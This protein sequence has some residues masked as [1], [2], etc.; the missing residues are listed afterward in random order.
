MLI[1]FLLLYSLSAL[2]TVTELSDEEIRNHHMS[3]IK[4]NQVENQLLQNDVFNDCRKKN[5]FKADDT[6]DSKDLK[7]KA[8]AQCFHDNLPKD[9][10]SLKKISDTLDLQSYGLVNGKDSSSIVDY[11]T[12]KISKSLTGVDPKETDQAKQLEDLKFGKRK[13]VDQRVFLDLYTN[14]LVKSALQ[15]VSR[16]CFENLAQ[17]K[18]LKNK[19]GSSIEDYW[20]NLSQLYKTSQDKNGKTIKIADED[21]LTDIFDPK[22]SFLDT[23]KIKDL[24]D[25]KETYNAIMQGIAQQAIKPAF[26]QEFFA[27]CQSAIKPLCDFHRKEVEKKLSPSSTTTPPPSNTTL[28]VS[29]RYADSKNLKMEKGESACLTLDRLTAI[30]GAIKKSELVGKQFDEMGE[31]KGD[32]ALRML[33]TPQMYARGKG[34][35]EESLDDISNMTSSDIIDNE[36]FTEIKNLDEKCKNSPTDPECDQFLVKSDN[37]DKAITH[38]ENE[39]NLKREIEI[40]RAKEL[41]KK[42]QKSLIEYL[43]DQGLFDL[44]AK[45]KASANG[46]APIDIEKELKI[47]YEA[48][49]IAAIDAIKFKVGKRQIS[50]K[51]LSDLESQNPN[52]KSQIIQENIGDVKAEKIRMAQVIMFNNIITSQLDLKDTSGKTIG[53]NVGGWKKE[54]KGLDKENGINPNLFDGI[55]AEAEKNESKSDDTSIAGSGL[56]DSILGK[57][58]D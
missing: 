49:K 26:H 50:E 40:A 30:R 25:K 22:D 7:V 35:G 15:E 53:R 33:S 4:D 14:Q 8:A 27:F 39:M 11:L 3:L 44:S 54:F 34:Q 12:R 46:G 32:F 18:P 55:Q 21:Q 1:L 51:T 56:I 37:L 19:N 29:Q 6:Q 17:I 5:E 47:I 20:A 36:D 41:Q 48:R 38:I 9:A 45:V 57:T 42:D 24:K 43:D 16:F 31:K 13:M 52:E 23:T 28:A 58:E 2:A 10:E